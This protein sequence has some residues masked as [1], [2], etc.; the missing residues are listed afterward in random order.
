MA[1]A[2]DLVRRSGAVAGALTTADRYADDARR[3]VA[4]L[5]QT[6][7]GRRAGRL[8][9]TYATWSLGTLMDTRYLGAL[10]APG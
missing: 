4:H 1:A 5:N 6:A 7:G 8:P 10:T 9:R 2:L 3:A